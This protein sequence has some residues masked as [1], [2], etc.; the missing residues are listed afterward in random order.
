MDRLLLVK[1]S[2]RLYE[3]GVLRG[4]KQKPH[5][6]YREYPFR[7][8]HSTTECVCQ[9][10]CAKKS[11]RETRIEKI[12]LQFFG[13]IQ[14]TRY[15]DTR[16]A[17]TVTA[18]R[19]LYLVSCISVSCISSTNPNLNSFPQ[20]RGRSLASPSKHVITLLDT[21]NSVCPKVSRRPYR[22]SP[23]HGGTS[24]GCRPP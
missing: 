3:N 2:H 10:F 15:K 23:P 13:E 4:D 19:V 22:R 12:K 17:K 9:G 24:R 11:H 8:H 14:V 16:Y 1:T 6:H 21:Q 20:K 18:A 5:T 7:F